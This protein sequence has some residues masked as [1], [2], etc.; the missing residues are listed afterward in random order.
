MGGV[1]GARG[2]S[3][4]ASPCA[5]LAPV[6]LC[7]PRPRPPHRAPCVLPRLLRAARCSLLRALAGGATS[8]APLGL[9]TSCARPLFWVLR[10]PARV[11]RSLDRARHTRLPSLRS[12]RAGLRNRVA[13]VWGR[14]LP[15][16]TRAPFGFWLTPCAC[17]LP[18]L[19]RSPLGALR[20]FCALRARGRRAEFVPLT[21]LY[22]L[23]AFCCCAY[24]LFLR[25]ARV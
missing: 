20:P 21:A 2:R 25:F 13:L 11:A 6:S 14:T 4:R 12:A 19:R 8:C 16:P 23:R 15:P 10:R 5:T 1:C 17:P 9:A 7:A 22:A 24:R 3:A 18:A